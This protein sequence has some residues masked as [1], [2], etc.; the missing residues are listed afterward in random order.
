[1]EVRSLKFRGKWIYG[2]ND[3]VYGG[4]VSNEQHASITTYDSM[5]EV[6]PSTVGQYTGLRDRNGKEIYEGDI[7]EIGFNED[8]VTTKHKC[9][10]RW[11]DMNAAFALYTN[12]KGEGPWHG[13]LMN[14]C[15]IIGN[16]HDNPD[17]I[18]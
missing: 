1:M 12:E 18:K 15:I 13:W 3:W 5:K 14:N 8:G 11:N 4:I 7:I 10:V 6:D 16:I 17:L 9:V 2:D